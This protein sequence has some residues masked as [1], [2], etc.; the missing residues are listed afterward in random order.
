[1]TDVDNPASPSHRNHLISTNGK[2]AVLIEP[3]IPLLESTVSQLL[4][5][6]DGHY[7]ERCGFIS[8][9]E[10]NIYPV[11][12]A[13]EFAS[14]NFYMDEDDAVEAIRNIYDRDH[15]EIMG[16]YHTHPNG[17]PWPSPRDILGWPKV[18]LGWRYF[19]VSRGNVTEWRLIS[20]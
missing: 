11:H 3:E 20:D 7:L 16:I 19:L 10:Q 9:H 2:R 4:E 13:H 14:M 15:D 6:L 12:N 17:Y 8:K 1:M 5:E 18:E